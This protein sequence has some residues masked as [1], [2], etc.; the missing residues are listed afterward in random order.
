ANLAI[1]TPREGATAGTGMQQVR[2]GASNTVLITE[3]AGRPA[4]Y[5]RGGIIGPNTIAA[6]GGN[7]AVASAVVVGAPWPSPAADAPPPGTT[8]PPDNTHTA[9][10][11]RPVNCTNNQETF[12]FHMGGVNMVFADGAVHFI[13]QDMNT[14]TYP[15][16][17]TMRGGEVVSANDY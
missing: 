4:H 8:R 5:V 11:P 7:P 15:R 14:R 12:S 9:P 16:L 10:A 1:M 13:G 2:D 3:A 17:L 6:S